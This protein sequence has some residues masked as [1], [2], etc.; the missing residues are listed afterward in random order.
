M[1]RTIIFLF[2]Y[3]IVRAA[4]ITGVFTSFDSLV[5]QNGG[6]YPYEAPANP[7]WIATLSWAMDGNV[8]APGDT[9]TLHMPCT[10]KLAY[11]R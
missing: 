8:V 9:F 6:T 11:N 5:F 10:F 7:S 2:F 4:E 3:L 1:L